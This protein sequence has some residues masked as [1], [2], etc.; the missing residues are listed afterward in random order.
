M[1][2]LLQPSFYFVTNGVPSFIGKS[3][4]VQGMNVAAAAFAI[5]TMTRDPSPSV[6]WCLRLLVSVELDDS[7]LPLAG[8][9]LALE[10]DVDLTVR[11]TLHLRQEE[12]R[13]NETE[14]TSASPDV[15]ALSAEVGLLRCV[16]LVSTTILPLE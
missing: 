4:A 16:S 7:L 9:N 5:T 12:V 14:E 13:H 15:T 2:L 11:T 10:E 1:Q 8:R 6:F 3:K